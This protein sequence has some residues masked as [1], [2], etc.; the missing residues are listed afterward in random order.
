MQREICKGRWI[1]ITIV[2][3]QL[4]EWWPKTCTVL[5]CKMCSYG[6][7][8]LSKLRKKLIL[9]NLVYKRLKG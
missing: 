6:Y 1:V 8:E 5:Y 4:M 3:K 2:Q 7:E 9:I